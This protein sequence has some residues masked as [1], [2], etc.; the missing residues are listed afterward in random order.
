MLPF[1]IN[2][3]SHFQAEDPFYPNPPKAKA[4]VG[5]G[6]HENTLGGDTGEWCG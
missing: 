3:L 2:E 1:G 6:G 4:T 5:L